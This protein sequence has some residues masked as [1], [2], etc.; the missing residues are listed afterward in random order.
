MQVVKWFVVVILI[1]V[2]AA[3]AAGQAGLLKGHAP[4]NL[5]VRDGRLLPPSNTPNS[6][7]S[8]AGLYPG[9][10][11]RVQSAV[12]PLPVKGSGAA[13]MAKIRSVV[14]NMNGA[15]IVKSEPGYLYAQ[16]TT[17]VMKFVDDVEFWFDPAAN[18]IHVRS[19]S[20]LGSKDFGANRERID[21][22]RRRLATL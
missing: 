17:P 16:F 4:A 21:T 14:E 8:Q 15:D 12:A 6:V 9:H 13:T 20:R 1:V 5:G 7:S 22:I 18:V 10:S 11:M 2:V 19:A 3:V